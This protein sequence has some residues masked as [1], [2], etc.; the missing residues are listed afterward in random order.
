VLACS[1]W[2]KD[3]E[4]GDLVC[5]QITDPQAEEVRGWRLPPGVGLAHWVVDHGQSLV[6]PDTRREPRH[7]RGVD[8][9]TSLE[10]RSVLTAP[11]Q[12][13]QEVVGVIQ[14]VDTAVSRFTETDVTLMEALAASAAGAIENARLFTELKNA[15]AQL[16]NQERLAALGQMSATIAHELRNP[17]MAIRMG[18]EYLLQD[19]ARDDAR[20]RG[21]ALMQSNMDRID[22]LIEDIL[23]LSRPT[24]PKLAPDLLL[25]LLEEEVARWELPLASK[26]LTLHTDLARQLRPAALDGE[27]MCRALTNLIGNSVDA[28]APGGKMTLTLH[29]DDHHQIIRLTDDGPGISPEHLPHIFEPFYTTKSRGTGLGLSIVKQIIDYHQ[30]QIEVESEVGVGTTFTIRLPL[31]QNEPIG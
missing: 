26:E 23:F 17:L 16:V 7:F 6:V 20:W 11:L 30:G 24:Q 15:Q 13:K 27:Q 4:T 2:L 25:P 19:V 10:I 12:G 14:V 5:R 3:R 9:Q 21:A 28:L 1:V 31:L 29:A 8:E 22:R 18:V